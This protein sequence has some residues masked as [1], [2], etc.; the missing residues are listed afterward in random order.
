HRRAWRGLPAAVAWRAGR[1]RAQQIELQGRLDRTAVRAVAA[2]E[3]AS[4][5]DCRT[6]RA[7]GTADIGSAD[8]QDQQG[9]GR[10]H[11]GVT[12]AAADCRLPAGAGTGDALAAAAVDPAAAPAARRRAPA[13]GPAQAAASRADL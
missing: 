5:S 12:A 1:W 9:Q 2:V 11:A 13:P 4:R 6:G 10:Q 8:R 7:A 3:P